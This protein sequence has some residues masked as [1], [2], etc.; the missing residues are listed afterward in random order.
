MRGGKKCEG[1]TIQTYV[2]MVTIAGTAMK[3][4]IWP[5]AWQYKCN[6]CENQFQTE[7]E[8]F[9]H[10][11]NLHA[12]LVPA[13]KNYLRK[14][15]TFENECWFSHKNKNEEKSLEKN[16]DRILLERLI[17]MVEKLTAR[18]VEIESKWFFEKSSK[19]IENKPKQESNKK[20]NWNRRTRMRNT[21]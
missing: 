17:I 20:K 12:E 14:N 15:C 21:L 11:K 18:I 13:C 2:F 7:P 8:L 4:N 1:V 16:E 19:M 6:F 10:K 9:K 3:N 5:I